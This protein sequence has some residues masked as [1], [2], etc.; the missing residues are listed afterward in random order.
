VKTRSNRKG[1]ERERDFNIKSMKGAR[2]QKKKKGGERF[3][4]E[5]KKYGKKRKERK[6]G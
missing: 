1:R 2:H 5:K 6:E 3:I 4:Q